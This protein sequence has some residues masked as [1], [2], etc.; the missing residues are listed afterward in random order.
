[1]VIHLGE[2]RVAGSSWSWSTSPSGALVTLRLARPVW[3]ARL[4]TVP[5]RSRWRWWCYRRRWQRVMTIAGL[6]P[7]Y[8]GRVTLP[9]LGKVQPVRAPT[10]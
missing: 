7:L 8:R 10:W 3:F 5:A 2:G 1:M 6:A 9:V 4:V